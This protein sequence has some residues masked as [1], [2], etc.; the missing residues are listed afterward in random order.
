MIRAAISAGLLLALVAGAAAAHKGATGVVKQR[1]EAM[2]SMAQATQSVKAEL[3]KGASYDPAVVVSHA[4]TIETH[5]GE[6]LVALY[7][8]GSDGHP[9]E[10]RPKI[11]SEPEKFAEAADNLKIQARALA[12]AAKISAPPNAEFKAL[13]QAC[14]VC[15]KSFRAKRK[16]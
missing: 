14:A 11:W 8:K 15:H 12:A 4:K 7:P 10:A 3:R 16:K 2:K 13:L 9:S 5:A 6:D 1:M